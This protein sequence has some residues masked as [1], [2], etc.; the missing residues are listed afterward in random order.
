MARAIFSSRWSGTCRTLQEGV[1]GPER[2]LEE[3]PPVGQKGRRG[4]GSH[5]WGRQGEESSA[6]LTLLLRLGGP[7]RSASRPGS[8]T[9][10]G[11]HGL[12][13]VS[14]NEGEVVPP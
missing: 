2:L 5:G 9:G 11:L 8:G 12:H 7:G 10:D 3:G 1:E 13:P 6:S 14:Y 4:G